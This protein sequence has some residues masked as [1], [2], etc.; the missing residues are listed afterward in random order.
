[1][2][3]DAIGIVSENPNRSIEFFKILG[4]E[5]KQYENSGHYEGTTPSG[6]RIMLD[7]VEMIRTID[8]NWQKSRG[9]GL[10]LCFKQDSPL[11]IDDLYQRITHAGFSGVKAPW[12]AFW[13]HRYACVADPDGNQIDLFASL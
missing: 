8:P 9:N 13:G 12:N 2:G 6:V 4:V 5:I 10:V 1:M 7:T 11:Q 3:F